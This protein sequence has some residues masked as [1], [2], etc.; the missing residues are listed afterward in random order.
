MVN[1]L[2]DIRILGV[3]PVEPSEALFREALETQ[4]G[5]D[6][7][8]RALNRARARVHEHFAGL[9][10]I[11]IVV[12]PTD[13]EVEWS[14][15]TQPADAQPESNWQVPYDEQFVDCTAGHWV[16]YMHYLDVGTPLQ[17]QIGTVPMP[18]PSRMPESLAS[19]Q[20]TVP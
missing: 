11:S 19:I 8:G 15:I 10:L 17:T 4:W 18:M 14:R 13:A 16:F 7:S 20:Y 9:Y 12:E 5:S 2:R 6:L 3:H 1:A